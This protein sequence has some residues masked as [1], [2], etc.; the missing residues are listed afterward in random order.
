MAAT[1]NCT[2]LNGTLLEMCVTLFDAA[3]TVTPINCFDTTTL[4]LGYTTSE[5]TCANYSSSTEKLAGLLGDQGTI[6]LGNTAWLIISSALV[7]IMTPGV[8]LFYAGLAGEEAASNTLLM[9]YAALCIVTVQWFLFGY[10][11]AFGPGTAGLGTFSFGAMN[12]VGF[13]PSG[14][15]TAGIP[16]IVFVAFQCMFAQITPA[17]ISGALIGRMKFSAWCI[18]VFIWTT[19]IYDPIAHWVW[20]FNIDPSTGTSYAS[21]F[22]GSLGSL[23]FAGG[24]VIHISSGVAALA[25]AIVLGP[26]KKSKEEMT[27]HNVP[28]IILGAT[29]LWFGWFGFNAGSATSASPLASF[30]FINTHLATAMATLSWIAMEKLVGSSPTVAG[31]ASG[32]VAGL[33][34]ITPGC[35]FVTPWASVIFGIVVS[36]ICYGAAQLRKKFPV[37]DTLDSFAVHGVGGAV[38]AFLT[39]LFADPTINPPFTGAFYGNPIQIGYQMAAIVTSAVFSFVGSFLIMLFLKFTIGV[40]LDEESERMGIDISEHGGS[41]YQTPGNPVAANEASVL[42]KEKEL[43]LSN[44]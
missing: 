7:M 9:S 35:G 40:R 23:D 44:L 21:G 25:C 30:A 27:P 6:D 43:S 41:A 19:V 24:T 12:M 37:D 28:M 8:G 5:G 17:I 29:F 10:S 38:G 2:S 16:H 1:L 4:P 33:V 11:L 31:A 14:G 3:Q 22:L 13:A 36:P 34:A 42:E 18:F 15:Y 26:R 20:S 39:G 32:A